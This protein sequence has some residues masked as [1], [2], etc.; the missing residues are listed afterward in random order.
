MLP[1]PLSLT[2]RTLYS[3]LNELAISLGVSEH[4]GR[5]PGTISR[6]SVKGADYLYYQY[7]DLDGRTRQAYIGP[8]NEATRARLKD[9]EARIADRES[10]LARLNE[11]RAAFIAAGGT[12]IE[13]TPMRVLRGLADGGVL[14]P[15][16]GCA[17][18]VGT[19]AFIALGNLLGVRWAS[20]IRTQDIDLAGTADIELG[21][22]RPDIP[23][24]EI[25]DQLGMGFIP[26]P[27]LD[28]KTPTTSYRV[29]GQEVRVDLL[30]PL[31][32]KPASEPVFVPSLNA[33]A[34]PVRF[35]D[36][37]LESPVAV[38]LVGRR[39]QVL[40]N[41]PAPE[42]FALH[43]LL[44][45]ESRASAFAAKAE[46][47]RMQAG[48][49]LQV[50]LQEAPDGVEAAKS[51]LVSRGKGWAEKFERA[52]KKCQKDFPDVVNWLRGF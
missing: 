30:V 38:T 50:L 19:Y 15:G 48:Q 24:P 29:R 9:I 16:L 45:S 42:R 39:T 11:L 25:L 51:D 36:Y 23:T 40:A 21:V 22:S 28:P 17:Q 4:L 7:R 6:K 26:V 5:A 33:L 34:Q 14:R 18:L 2:A 13:H 8:D 12:A 20:Q 52:L 46:K 32:G 44:V 10:D 27:T 43:K 41:V 37:L 1:T 35:L 3:E 47:D 31:R 49:V